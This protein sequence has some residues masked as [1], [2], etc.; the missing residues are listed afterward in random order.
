MTTAITAEHLS[1]EYYIGKYDSG[2]F[3]SKVHGLLG[4]LLRKSAGSGTTNR[5]INALEDISFTIAQG[6]CTGI[7]GPNGSGKSTLLKILSGITL[8]SGG[9]VTIRG[10]VA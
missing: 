2:Y 1:K 4:S 10:T 6:E 5:S 7:I 8:P 9:K 3:F